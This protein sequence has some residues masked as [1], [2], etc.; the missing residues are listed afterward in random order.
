MK[1]TSNSSNSSLRRHR[2]SSLAFGHSS[3]QFWREKSA[4]GIFAL[5]KTPKIRLSQIASLLAQNAIP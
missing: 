4:V 1:E 2:H 3:K 5:S